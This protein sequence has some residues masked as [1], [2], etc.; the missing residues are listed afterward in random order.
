MIVLPGSEEFLN[1][2]LQRLDLLLHREILRLRARYQLSLDEFR[3]L[4]ISDQQVDALI[5]GMSQ[6]S[7]SPDSEGLTSRAEA[8]R[9][10]SRAKLA[11][12]STWAR[13]TGEYSLSPCE[14]DILLLALAPEIDLKYETLYGYLHNDVTRKNPSCDLA[15]RVLSSSPRQRW[16]VRQY[17]LPDSNLFR[18]GLIAPAAEQRTRLFGIEF[19][20]PPAVARGVL[21]MDRVEIPQRGW[22]EIPLP[23]NTLGLLRRLSELIGQTATIVVFEGDDRQVARMAAEAVCSTRNLP[24]LNIDLGVERLATLARRIRLEQ[25]LHARAIYLSHT[26]ALW[27]QDG[28]PSAEAARFAEELAAAPGPLLFGFS[29]EESWRVLLRGVRVLCVQTPAPDAGRRAELWAAAAKRAGHTAPP[30]DIEE[31]AARFVLSPNQIE[32]AAISAADRLNLEQPPEPLRLGGLADAARNQSDQSL[33]MMA[34]KVVLTHSWEDVV[35]P[36]ATLRQVKEVVAAARHR[37]LVYE[38]WGLG[39]R[40][41]PGSGVNALFSGAS[42][43]G[44]TLTASVVASELGLDLYQIDLSRVISK[45][46]GETEKNLDRVFRAAHGSNAI[47]FFDEADALFGKRSE[48]KDAHDRYA[49]IEIAYLLQKMEEHDGIAILATNLGKNIDDAFSRRLQYIVEFPLPDEPLRLR[50]WQGMFSPRTPLAPDVDLEFLARQFRLTGG[51]IRNVILS[52]AFLAADN[53]K[54]IDMELLTKA[55]ARQMIKQGRTVT[56]AD[57]KQYYA[58]VASGDARE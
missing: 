39:A 48:V 3:G 1:T 10:E 57:F 50:L 19:T 32:A 24:L 35:L 52:A 14:E 23:E 4:Y 40:L 16:E 28:L 15:A 30:A 43:T 41:A 13:V 49:N 33:R 47:L 8:L 26:E 29:K 37:T 17:L 27:S 45:Y 54:I 36:G 58:L 21:E 2:Q 25:R 20:V 55:M 44:K 6:E 38:R 51:D 22:E 11:C 18:E 7:G 31:V 46:I 34:R 56:G 9:E 53:G 12:E 42:G 5:L